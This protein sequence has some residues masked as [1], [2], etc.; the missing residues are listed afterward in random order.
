MWFCLPTKGKIVFSHPHLSSLSQPVRA[1]RRAKRR[2]TRLLQ[3]GGR[4]APSSSLLTSI[5]ILSRSLHLSF[6]LPVKI[7]WIFRVSLVATQEVV[8]VLQI[9]R[10]WSCSDRPVSSAALAREMVSS[11]TPTLP[12]LASLGSHSGPSACSSPRWATLPQAR[13]RRRALLRCGSTTAAAASCATPARRPLLA[14]PRLHGYH[15][16]RRSP[17]LDDSDVE[18]AQARSSIFAVA[19]S[20][21]RGLRFEVRK[22]GDQGKRWKKMSHLGPLLTI[23]L[24]FAV[25]IPLK[26]NGTIEVKMKL[27]MLKSGCAF[28]SIL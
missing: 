14:H 18:V 9:S 12:L 15:Q 27:C 17:A 4:R 13:A 24:C 19:A 11:S 25:H 26:H 22:P 7:G 10:R 3:G 6:S 8:L 20:L 21:N 16:Q 23:F 1:W 2:R 5:P 28:H